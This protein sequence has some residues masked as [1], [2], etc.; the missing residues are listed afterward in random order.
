MNKRDLGAIAGISIAI[1]VIARMWTGLDTPDSSFYTS[2]ALFGDQVTDRAPFDSYY[3][4]RLGYIG[5]LMLLTTLTTPEI[6][7]VIY[8]FILIAVIVGSVYSLL[9]RLTPTNSNLISTNLTRI[10]LTSA[11][12][13]STVILS[14]LGNPYLTGFILAATC[15]VI[16]LVATNRTGLVVVAGV[17]VGWSAQVNPAGSL[18]VATLFIATAVFIHQRIRTYI[19]AAIAA[20]IAFV[21]FIGVGTL[22][23][24][25]LSW[26]ETFNATRDMNLSDFASRSPVWLT[27]ISLLVPLAVLIL[28]ITTWWF[29]RENNA[30]RF[31]LVVSSVSVSFLMVFSPLMGGI[32]MEAPMY[33]SMLWPPAMIAAALIFSNFLNLRT[34]QWWFYA[35]SLLVIIGAGVL[36]PTLTFAVGAIIAIGMV[37]AALLASKR[38]VTQTATLGLVAVTIFMASA[39]LLQNSRTDLGLYFLSPYSWAFA[40]NPIAGKIGS[41]I[42]VQEWLLANTSNSDQILTWVDGSWI[43]GDRELYAVAAMQLWG[44]NRLTLEPVVDDYARAVLEQADPSVIAL[45]GRSQSAITTMWESIPGAGPLTCTDFTWPVA[46]NTDFPADSG[47]ACLSRLHLP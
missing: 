30:H 34:Q 20:G 4:T 5:P 16:A 31:A 1:F 7:Y 25:G 38:A 47:I 35:L 36:Q 29:N 45:Y 10:Y 41:A 33:Q 32:A 3:W 14:Y 8:R 21:F 23:F 6:G 12:A 39:Q 40:P 18:L 11:A 43:E 28:A 24:P 26:W 44:E 13:T 17:V 2:L 42:R 15:A 19:F 9:K 46:S 27:D 22:I 37:L